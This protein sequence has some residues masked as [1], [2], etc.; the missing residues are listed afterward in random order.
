MG[1]R[2]LWATA[3]SA[4]WF[5]ET[6]RE[7]NF[8]ETDREV[9]FSIDRRKVSESHLGSAKLN[10]TEVAHNSA[11]N[12]LDGGEELQSVRNDWSDGSKRSI[13]SIQ[14]ELTS[15]TSPFWT[16]IGSNVSHY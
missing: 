6:D 16:S 13:A 15:S 12:K 5:R 14:I 10:E 7:V 8:R 2:A 3:S 1:F 11:V 4:S 9:N